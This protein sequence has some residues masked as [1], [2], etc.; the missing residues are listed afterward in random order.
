[1]RLSFRARFRRGATLGLALLLL[2]TFSAIGT[3]QAE[4]QENGAS[5]S[6]PID[7]NRASEEVLTT[8][9]GIGETTADRIVTWREEHGPFRRVEDLMKVR[10][11]GEKS[12]QKI[13]PYV[14]VGKF[15]S[16]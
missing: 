3:A 7:I 8:I 15:K 13:R 6:S 1:M 16:K 4:T 11:I 9:P 14:K 10:G 12:F 5:T 2:A